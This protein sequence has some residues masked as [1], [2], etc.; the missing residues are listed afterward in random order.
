MG[1]Y[2]NNNHNSNNHNSNNNSI[3]YDHDSIIRD[4]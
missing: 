4:Q 2:N 1:I 3:E